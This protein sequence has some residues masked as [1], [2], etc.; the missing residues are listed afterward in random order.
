MVHQKMMIVFRPT[1][2]NKI[3]TLYLAEEGEVNEGV[4]GTFPNLFD[5]LAAK[6]VF[7]DAEI[8]RLRTKLAAGQSCWSQVHVK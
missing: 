7:Q 3:Q 5:E 6:F 2:F 1:S 4:E 8:D